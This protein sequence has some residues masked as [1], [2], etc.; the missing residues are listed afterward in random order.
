[1]KKKL[2][3]L[4]LVLI[5]PMMVLAGCGSKDYEQK[6]T[7]VYAG[8]TFTRITDKGFIYEGFSDA[9]IYVHNETRVMY[10]GR[11]DSGYFTALLN[12]DGTPMLWEGEL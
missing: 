11:M 2:L 6:T 12:A 7:Y 9:D 1:M 3:C 10:I 4:L 5:M 8:V